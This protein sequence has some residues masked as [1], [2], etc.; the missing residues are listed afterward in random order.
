MIRIYYDSIGI[1]LRIAY[2][3][4]MILRNYQYIDS[5]NFINLKMAITNSPGNIP[6]MRWIKLKPRSWAISG[7]N[8][9]K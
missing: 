2:Y 7:M 8:M 4:L 1:S 5:I 3:C 9:K 6:E